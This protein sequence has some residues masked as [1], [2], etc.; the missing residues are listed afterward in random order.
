MQSTIGKRGHPASSSTSQRDYRL[1]HWVS[2]D[3]QDGGFEAY[4]SKFARV[5]PG[6]SE[7]NR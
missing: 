2:V 3:L 6:L 1:A 5:N 4:R 7:K